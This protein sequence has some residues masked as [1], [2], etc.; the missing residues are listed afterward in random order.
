MS[1]L[2]EKIKRHISWELFWF[3]ATRSLVGIV[4]IVYALVQFSELGVKTAA[5]FLAVG[6]VWTLLFWWRTIA[7]YKK[8]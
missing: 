2:K 4:I 8:M 7:N 5:S 6:I 1:V 3:F